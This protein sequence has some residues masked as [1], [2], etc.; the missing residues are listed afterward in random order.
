MLP[1]YEK[2]VVVKVWLL[3]IGDADKCWY[4]S[5]TKNTLK[6][7]GILS[8]FNRHAVDLFPS[9]DGTVINKKLSLLTMYSSEDDTT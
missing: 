5:V 1:P 6:T 7:N 4:M 3:E 8:E 2:Y 9:Y